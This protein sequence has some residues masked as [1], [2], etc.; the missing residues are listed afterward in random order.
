MGIFPASIFPDL[1]PLAIVNYA[2]TGEVPYSIL[3]AKSK[4]IGFISE[5][6][7]GYFQKIAPRTWKPVGTKDYPEFFE[8]IEIPPHAINESVP[9][10]REWKRIKSYIDEVH[11]VIIDKTNNGYARIPGWNWDILIS[12]KGISHLLNESE[13]RLAIATAKFIPEIIEKSVF[14]VSEKD[15]HNQS[16]QETKVIHKFASAIRYKNEIYPIKVTTK[17]LLYELREIRYY[18][19]ELL[20]MDIE[21]PWRDP[22][23]PVALPPA[24]GAFKSQL[25][26]ENPWRNLDL[27]VKPFKPS[28]AGAFKFKTKDLLE[29]VKLKNEISKTKRIKKG[30][31]MN[32]QIATIVKST[33]AT[34][35]QLSPDEIEILKA[36]KRQEGEVWTQP[37]GRKVTKRGGRIIPVSD[38]QRGKKEEKPGSG[39]K[40]KQATPEKK[41]NSSLN[42]SELEKKARDNNFKNLSKLIDSFTNRDVSDMD[43]NKY[44]EGLKQIAQKFTPKQVAIIKNYKNYMGRIEKEYSNIES[45]FIE[46]DQEGKK[47]AAK[48]R[49][50]KKKFAELEDRF[51]DLVNERSYIDTKRGVYSAKAMSAII[52]AHNIKQ[53]KPGTEKR[54]YVNSFLDDLAGIIKS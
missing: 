29:F 47:E 40:P 13:N 50:S 52:G 7:K 31:N 23:N 51:D 43:P 3:K 37:S 28:T 53:I 46:L 2:N 35:N 25:N 5:W 14:C 19:H 39:N 18:H 9:K 41:S 33:L 10:P 21:R 6:S 30:K 26:D 8:P 4:P 24:P 1:P 12:K 11:K 34:I 45:K 38:L 27:L 44:V 42:D 17:Q 36:K 22:D 32:S 16:K 49:S 48:K 54:E 20:E 15:R